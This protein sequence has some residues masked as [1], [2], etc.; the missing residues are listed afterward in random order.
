MLHLLPCF[1]IFFY[2]LLDAVIVTDYTAS[3]GGIVDE[4]EMIQ[5]EVA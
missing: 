2:G 5:K 4:L 3:N 1:I